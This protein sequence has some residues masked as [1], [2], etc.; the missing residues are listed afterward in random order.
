MTTAQAALVPTRRARVAAPRAVG[1]GRAFGRVT[2]TGYLGMGYEGGRTVPL[3][4]AQVRAYVPGTDTV[5]P[6]PLY[7]D[8]AAAAPAA[9]P[10]LTDDSGAVALWADAPGRLELVCAAAGYL[11][12]RLVLDLEPVPAEAGEAIDAYTKAESD[13]LFLTQAEADSLFLTVADG[14]ARYTQG[15]LTQA[16]ADAR[17][18]LKTDPDPYP[19]YLTAGE[20]PPSDVTVTTDASLTATESPANTFAL[21]VRLS[22]DAGNALALRGNGLYGTDTTG[23]GGGAVSSVNGEVGDVVLT[24][25]EVGASPAAHNHDALYEP[26]D[27]AYTKAEADARYQPTGSYS[28]T[29]H[30]H[31]AS[32]ATTGHAHTGFWVAPAGTSPKITVQASAPSSP[33]TGD[34]WIW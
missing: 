16:A 33:A 28:L 31:D 3:H 8:E 30:N 6:D 27:T 18:P 10:L 32:Y 29:T 5:W 24:A 7:L 25:A 1:Y 9:F 22:P 23:G 17:Y 12:Q 4:G 21:G 2:V 19:Q 13:A 14:D 34:V 11:P 26:L 15:G 20:V